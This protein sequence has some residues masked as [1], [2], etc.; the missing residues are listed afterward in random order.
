MRMETLPIRLKPGQDLR[1]AIEEAATD[2]GCR[3]AFVLAGI[4]SL[5]QAQIR[6]AGTDEPRLVCGNLEVVALS[7]TIASDASHL[8]A[9]LA[10]ASGDVLGGH[11][12]YGCIVGTT[13]EVLLALLPV[14]HFTREL[15]LATGYDELIV[16]QISEHDS[17]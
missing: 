4:G 17:T 10:T 15:D 3:A 11:V 5:A 9:A 16:R 6:L 7:G 12:A 1:R 2:K 14:W 8:H 13:A